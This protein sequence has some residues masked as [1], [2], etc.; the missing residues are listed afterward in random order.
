VFEEKTVSELMLLYSV[1][2][3]NHAWFLPWYHMKRR[4]R[5]LQK[6]EKITIKDERNNDR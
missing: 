2:H 4:N 1:F 5:N 6:N 3:F